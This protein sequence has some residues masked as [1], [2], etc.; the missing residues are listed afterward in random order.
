PS[1][2]VTKG[3]SW[4]LF[5]FAIFTAVPFLIVYGIAFCHLFPEFGE[6]IQTV[7]AA[8]KAGD[9]NAIQ[10]GGLAFQTALPSKLMLMLGLNTVFN[11]IFIPFS[12][13]SGGVA[14]RMIAEGDGGA[15]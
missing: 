7:F 5:F 2:E 11:L 9:K 12:I 14:Y 6:Y 13:V 3:N 4:Q 15:E 1:W 8:I 10:E